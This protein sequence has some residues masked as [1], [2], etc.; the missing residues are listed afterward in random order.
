MIRRTIL[1]ACAVL[2]CVTALG[3]S[4][5]A[6]EGHDMGKEHGRKLLADLEANAAR[7]GIS[8]QTV[9]QIRTIVAEGMA[10]GDS[11]RAELLEART[12]LRGLLSMPRPDEAAVMAQARKIGALDTKL[13]ELRLQTLLRVRPL[14]TDA[15]IEALHAIR[16]QRLAPVRDACRAEIAASCAD[17]VSGRETVHCLRAQH[18]QLSDACRA[19]LS[20]LHTGHAG[21]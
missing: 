3:A 9:A 18:D 13:L 21:P 6:G 2:L 20:A 14:L 12:A 4:A 1:L 7:L 8:D 19:A 16:Q 10:S 11:L 5:S 15:Q 17:A